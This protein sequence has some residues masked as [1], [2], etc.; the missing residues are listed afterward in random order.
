MILR[1]KNHQ[2]VRAVSDDDGCWK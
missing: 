1:L 2:I